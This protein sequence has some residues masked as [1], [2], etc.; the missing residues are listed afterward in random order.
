M[1]PG[2]SVGSALAARAAGFSTFYLVDTGAYANTDPETY[3]AM[4]RNWRGRGMPAVD[5]EDANS[6]HDVL[7]RGHVREEVKLLEDHTNIGA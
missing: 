1:G 3:K 4:S 2:D 6:F 7:E 5:I